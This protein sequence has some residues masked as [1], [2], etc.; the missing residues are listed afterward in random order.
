MISY[1]VLCDGKTFFSRP[2]L[3]KVEEDKVEQNKNT[4]LTK[5]EQKEYQM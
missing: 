3:I 4:L 2:D 5:D 1:L